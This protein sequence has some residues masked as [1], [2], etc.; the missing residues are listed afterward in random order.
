VNIKQGGDGGGA[1]PSDLDAL[2]LDDLPLDLPLAKAVPRL[3]NLVKSLRVTNN[4]LQQRLEKAS[5]E[6]QTLAQRQ[7]SLQV[8][9]PAAEDTIDASAATLLKQEITQAKQR[10]LDAE[11][12]QQMVLKTL[13]YERTRGQ[14]LEAELNRIKRNNEVAT[15]AMA[16]AASAKAAAAEKL[17]KEIEAH[18]VKLADVQKKKQRRMQSHLGQSMAGQRHSKSAARGIMSRHCLVARV[19]FSPLCPPNFVFLT[20]IYLFFCF[21]RTRAHWE[22]LQTWAVICAR[23]GIALYT[24]KT[25]PPRLLSPPTS[26]STPREASTR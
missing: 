11:S 19:A 16:S 24:D 8:S 9:A 17:K 14:Q 25:H 13:E 6:S 10:A 26:R 20:P 1:A 7:N 23:G 4:T 2:A 22:S 18:N 5:I 3:Q 15:S 21:A 12:Q